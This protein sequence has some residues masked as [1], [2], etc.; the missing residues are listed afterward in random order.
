MTK[1]REPPEDGGAAATKYRTLRKFC[2]KP[3]FE[4]R[5]ASW[6]KSAF[7]PLPNSHIVLRARSHEDTREGVG[8]CEQFHHNRSRHLIRQQAG[9]VPP[10][11]RM[12]NRRR[13]Q[14]VVAGGRT[15][16]KRPV[17]ALTSKK[18]GNN[19]HIN[20]K[21]PRARV[22]EEVPLS[23]PTRSRRGN[24]RW[25]DG[26]GR[27]RSGLEDE[28]LLR[29]STCTTGPRRRRRR[30][31][32]GFSPRRRAAGPPPAGDTCK[33]LESKAVPYGPVIH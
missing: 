6:H 16:S 15:H 9:G 33:S 5:N 24:S 4:N 2:Q 3:Q 20:G 29:T 30:C 14:A 1:L 12:P 11:R 32:S 13:H 25:I 18:T 7:S 19:C 31:H 22:L 23:Y 21:Q 8:N 10:R 28:L 26:R 27:R 17:R